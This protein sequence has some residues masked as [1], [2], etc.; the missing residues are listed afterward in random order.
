M[1]KRACSLS[2][3]AAVYYSRLGKL[4]ANEA[5][6]DSSVSRRPVPLLAR[7]GA[8]GKN[9]CLEILGGCGGLIKLL[10]ANESRF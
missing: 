6:R 10:D 7:I 3:R 4:R 5:R 8:E 2:K 9:T 1:T